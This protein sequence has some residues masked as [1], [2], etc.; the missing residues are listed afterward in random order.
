[1]RKVILTGN[2]LSVRLNQKKVLL[3]Y[4]NFKELAITNRGES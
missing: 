4:A 3:F 1:M 2:G